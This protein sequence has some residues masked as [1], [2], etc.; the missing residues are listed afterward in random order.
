MGKRRQGGF[1]LIEVIVVAAIIAILAGILVPLIFKEIDEAK[2]TR[3][4]ADLKSIS[5]AIMVMRKDTGNWPDLAASGGSCISTASLLYGSGN[6]P[7]GLA[8]MGYDQTNSFSFDAYLSADS[9][10]CYG[11]KWKGPYLA[12]V[13]ADP[14]GNA[15]LVNAWGFAGGGAV[16]ALSAGPNGIIETPAGAATPQGDD[17]GVV[18]TSRLVRD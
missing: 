14:W 5:T 7:D 10:G 4:G 17:I 6:L 3:A 18:L 12:T 15:Y 16:C 13:S 9:S 11:A 8:A 2:T 1:T